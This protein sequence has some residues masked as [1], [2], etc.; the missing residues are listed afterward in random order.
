MLNKILLLAKQKGCNN[1][2]LH[3]YYLNKKYINYNRNNIVNKKVEIIFYS[4]FFII[5]KIN[6]KCIVLIISKII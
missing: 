3:F 1:F 2:F 4:N 5:A 6:R